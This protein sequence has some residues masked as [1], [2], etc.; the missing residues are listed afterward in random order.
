MVLEDVP[1][2]HT[3]ARPAPCASCPARRRPRCGDRRRRGP[4]SPCPH[5]RAWRPAGPGRPASRSSSRSAAPAPPARSPPP[6]AA[7]RRPCRST[8]PRA[9]QDVSVRPTTTSAT[10]SAPRDR[11]LRKPR[12][13]PQRILSRPRQ[14]VFSPCT[15]KTLN[16]SSGDPPPRQHRGGENARRSLEGGCLPTQPQGILQLRES[17]AL[18]GPNMPKCASV[19]ASYLIGRL[20]VRS[21]IGTVREQSIEARP[22]GGSPAPV[23]TNALS[24]FTT[25]PTAPTAAQRG[26]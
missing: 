25:I 10:N 14:I 19:S 3:V 22:S 5:A 9:E 23:R 18:P 11:G 6:P 7:P 16:N 13:A 15:P 17:R 8:P 1:R 12:P 24:S 21:N 20:S 26:L 4:S 2:R